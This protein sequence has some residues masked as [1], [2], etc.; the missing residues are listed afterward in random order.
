MRASINSKTLKQFQRNPWPFQTTF[1]TPLKDLERFVSTFFAVHQPIES[2][3]VTIDGYVFEPKTLN[4]F[5]TERSVSEQVTH[6]V[7]LEAE[8]QQEVEALLSATLADWI[9]FLFIPSPKR[10]AIYA[11]HD[12]FTTFYAN[13]KGN[14]SKIVHA[15][16]EKGFKTIDDHI[17]TF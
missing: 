3:C 2:G 11:D 16:R 15:L 7:V 13:T 14:L 4:A 12:E 17:R 6:D 1:E 9:D 10:F 8:G 5:L